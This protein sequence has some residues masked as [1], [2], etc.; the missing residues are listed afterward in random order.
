MVSTCQASPVY[1]PAV[2]AR[3]SYEARYEPKAQGEYQVHISIG[4][5]P[6]QHSPLSFV[7]LAGFPDV[8]KSYVALPDPPLFSNQ[9]YELRLVTADKYGNACSTGGAYINPRISSHSLPAGQETD[10]EVEDLGNGT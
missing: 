9:Q 10:L 3:G 1:L 4:S 8:I 2:T 6:I 7:A 5:I